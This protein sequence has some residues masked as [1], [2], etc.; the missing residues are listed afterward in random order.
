MKLSG[1]MIVDL[2][3]VNACRIFSEVD[4]FMPDIVFFCILTVRSSN[5]D[6]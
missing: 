6:K 1:V 3:P 4:N 2:E 5:V